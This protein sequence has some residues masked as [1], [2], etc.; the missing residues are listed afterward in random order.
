MTRKEAQE[1]I[2]KVITSG[3][4]DGEIGAKLQEVCNCICEDSFSKCEMDVRCKSGYPN[5]C[6]GCPY[7]IEEE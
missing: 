3:I 5:Y 1:A 4:I 2:Y 6:E 7:L